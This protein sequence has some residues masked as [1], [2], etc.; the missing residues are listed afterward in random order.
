MEKI[1]E[2]EN[3]RVSFNTY[4]GKVQAVRG[5][6]FHL[7]K[8]ET[9]VVVG[10]S[11]CGKSVMSKSLVKLL[12]KHITEIGKDTKINLEGKDISKYSHKRMEKIRGK[13]IS[14]IFQDPMTYLNP[15]MKIGNQIAESLLIHQKISRRE[16]IEKTIEL[17]KLVKI[18]NPEKRV[19]QYPH[20]FSGGMRQ[21]V[22]IAIALACNPKILIADE[23]TT[24]LDVTT[25]ADIMDLIKEI[26]LKLNTSVMLITHDLGLAAE[27]ADR[28][29]VMYA[30]EVIETGTREEIFENPRHPYTLALLKSVPTIHD[31]KGELYYLKG[32]PP[33]LLNPPKACSFA[34]RCD[35]CMEVCKKLK[36]ERFNISDSHQVSCWLEHEYAPKKIERLEIGG[37]NE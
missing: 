34:N 18:P 24:A 36:P 11:G 1:L 21:R 28:I 7:N 10:E 13:D 19:N 9:L 31:K 35:Y 14:M 12:P 4:A 29:Q 5:V 17:L 16:A 30:G 23:P 20:E 25:Q 8:G 6:N 2:V 26:Q 15:T 3:L 32:T 33:D 37:K 27:V 22:I